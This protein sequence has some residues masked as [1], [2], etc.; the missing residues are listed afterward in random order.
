MLCIVCPNGCRLQ[1]EESAADNA[2][3]TAGIRV[4]G[5]QCERGVAFARAE[6]TN[7]TRTLTTTVRTAFREVPVLPVRTS[8]EIPKGK[9]P[10]VMAFLGTVTVT[11]PLGIGAVVAERVL[12]LD[13][14]IIV[15]SNIL[16]E[17]EA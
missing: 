10:E 13:S 12:G 3:D 6:L 11:E 2:A 1:V 4:M 8:G 14:D 5:N 7:P 17:T 9:I 15:T 16:K